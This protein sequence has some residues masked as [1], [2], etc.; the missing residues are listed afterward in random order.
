MRGKLK[1]ATLTG[2]HLFAPKRAHKLKLPL[3][4]KIAHTQCGPHCAVQRSSYKV[5]LAPCLQNTTQQKRTGF[6][7]QPPTVPPAYHTA[8]EYRRGM[9]NTNLLHAQLD[10]GQPRPWAASCRI[11]ENQGLGSLLPLAKQGQWKCA[12]H[13]RVSTDKEG[14][15]ASRPSRGTPHK[16]EA[17]SSSAPESN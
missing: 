3:C 1:V 16:L 8:D 7:T 12:T 13:A 11:Q 15:T 10:G 17:G 6:R 5:N 14:F 4:W 2:C 9:Y